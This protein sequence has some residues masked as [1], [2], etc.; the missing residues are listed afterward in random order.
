MALEQ[1][2][3]LA[4]ITAA[5]GVMVSL[6]YL[7]IQVRQS[8][9]VARTQ[10]RQSWMQLAQTEIHKVMEYPSVFRAFTADTISFDDKI[11]LNEWLI[12]SLRG[13]EFEWFQNQDGIIDD[14]HFQAYASAI[15]IILGTD[16]T[17]RFWAHHR[18]Q[19]HPGF[20]EFVDGL[21]AD[22]PSSNFWDLDAW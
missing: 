5:L 13:R 20:V 1:W 9:T 7:A 14:D 17:R 19:F 21:L 16:R 3:H 11:R 15:P 10:A 12:A 2:A 8:T 6:V 22:P 4:E 18:F